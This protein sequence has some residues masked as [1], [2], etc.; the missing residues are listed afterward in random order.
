MWLVARLVQGHRALGER[1]GL[2]VAA[3]EL[4]HGGLVHV[5]QC[6]HVVG[7]ERGGEPFGVAQGGRG[8]LVAALLRE[9]HARDRVHLCEVTAIAGRM[10]RGRGFGQMITDD[11]MVADLLV[12]EDQF[13]MRQPD[14]ARVVRRLGVLERPGVQGDGPRLLADGI[15][16]PAVQA[17]Q[18]GQQGLRDL[19]ANLIRRP[20]EHGGGPLRISSEQPRFGQRAANHELVEPLQVASLEQRFEQI[21]HRRAATPIEQRRGASQRGLQGRADHRCEYTPRDPWLM[22]APKRL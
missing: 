4:G 8:I 17:P 20:P 14:A 10:Q 12:A 11:R 19:L 1:H 7:A 15:G 5:G 3:P 6:Q 13:E 18:R 9:H 22:A 21:D 2:V 16:D